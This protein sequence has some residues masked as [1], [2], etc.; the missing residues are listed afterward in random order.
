MGHG[1]GRAA[2]EGGHAADG[3]TNLVDGDEFGRQEA[4]VE[5]GAHGVQNGADEQRAEE[6]LGHRPQGVDAVAADGEDD[7]LAFEKRFDVFHGK[8][9]FLS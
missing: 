5:L 1:H 4:D 3:V 9:L 6:A 2:H 7:V 8:H